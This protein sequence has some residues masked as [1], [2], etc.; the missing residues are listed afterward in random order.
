MYQLFYSTAIT[1]TRCTIR[2]E[3]EKWFSGK[4]DRSATDSKQH[5]LTVNLITKPQACALAAKTGQISVPKDHGDRSITIV[6]DVLKDS[7]IME[8]SGGD[9]V[10]HDEA[11]SRNEC[12]AFGW[13]LRFLLD[14]HGKCST[15]R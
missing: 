2:N 6:S 10:R 11:K 15:K 5:S 7:V 9:W 14:S 3:R 13:V 1:A 8:K 12:K 4:N